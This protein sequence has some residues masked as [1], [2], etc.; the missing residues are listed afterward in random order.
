MRASSLLASLWSLLSVGPSPLTAN[1][2]LPLPSVVRSDKKFITPHT[3]IN[4]EPPSGV[5]ASRRGFP[6]KFSFG[7]IRW[8]LQVHAGTMKSSNTLPDE[9][10]SCRTP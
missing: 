2:A 4:A 8:T 7:K 5:I 3:V 6:E 9:V 1:S 10:A